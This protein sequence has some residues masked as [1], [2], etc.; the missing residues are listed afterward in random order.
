[1]GITCAVSVRK[2][3]SSRI[4][5]SLYSD[6]INQALVELMT[7]AHDLVSLD[8]LHRLAIEA[9]FEQDFLSHFGSKVLPSKK[10]E[11]LE[12][13]IGLVHKKLSVALER[14]SV[15]KG[16]CNI[17][18]KVSPSFLIEFNLLVSYKSKLVFVALLLFAGSRK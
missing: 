11:D 17:S 15:I 16:R 14:E 18:D 10:S 7:M 13:W 4:S 12:F 9:G 8:N 6:S 1:M 2:L 5:C 3:G